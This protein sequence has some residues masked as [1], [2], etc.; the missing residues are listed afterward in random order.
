MASPIAA[1]LILCDAAQADPSGK[2]HM[3]GAG[4]SQTSTPTA[5]SAV[6]A[7]IK[8]PWDRAN[9]QIVFQLRLLSADGT[10]VTVEAPMGRQEMNAQGKIEVGRPA[11]LEPGSDI[12][13]AFVLSVPA[14]PLIPGRY[15]WRLDIGDDVYATSFQVRI[16]PSVR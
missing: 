2:I 9:Q 11:G 16:P 1:Q 8:V 5:P 6:A 4:W 14:L 10:P 7:L 3:L 12:D 15:Q 13:A